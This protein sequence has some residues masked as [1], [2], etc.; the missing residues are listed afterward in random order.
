MSPPKAAPGPVYHPGPISKFPA[1][2]LRPAR[3]FVTGH[4]PKGEGIFVND[5]DGAHHRLM[6]NGNAV[7]NIIYTTEGNP[8]D[9][10]NDKD[11]FYAR[12]NEVNRN[13][14]NVSQTEGRD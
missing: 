9:M 7:S 13:H 11:L 2:D 12:D 8:V 4:N 1:D 14:H 3:R 10:N 6:V 5:D